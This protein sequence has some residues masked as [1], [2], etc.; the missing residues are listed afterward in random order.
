[1]GDRRVRG[2]RAEFVLLVVLLGWAL[3]PLVLLLIHAGQTH[4]SFTGA[5]GLIGADGVLGADQL[6]YLAWVRDSGSHGL[7]SDLFSLAPANHIYLQPLFLISGVLWRAGLSLQL[8]YLLWKPIAAVALFLAALAWGRRAFSD[9]P[10][11]RF[12]SVAL[13]L[14]LYTPLAA[15]YSWGQTGS[16]SFRFQL[17]LL[18][19]ELLPATKLWGYVPS[20]LALALVPVALLSTELAIEP[21]GPRL[22]GRW[23]VYRR[24]LVV[25]ALAAGFAAWL[26]PWQ[27]VTLIA[28]FAGLA[29][30]QRRPAS[31]YLAVPAIG[32]ALPLSY[33]FLLK[34]GDI[35][36]KLGSQY[37]VI[38]RLPPLVLL[39]GFGPLVLIAGF[40]LVRPR[41]SVFEQSVLLWIAGC[42]FTY[43]ANDAFAPHAL[44]G[45]SFPLAVLLVRGGQRL[46]LPVAVGAA[47]VALATIP[48]L[49]Y[50]ARK[51]VNVT[52]SQT[53]QYYLPKGDQQALDWVRAH[54]PG[55]G[56]LAPTPFAAVI[57]ALTGRQVWAGDGYWTP[58]Y[59]ERAKL[60]DRLFGGRIHPAAKARAFVLGTGASVLV[61][62]CKHPADV[63]KPL[64]PIVLSVHRF[65]C[66]RVYVV[67]VRRSASR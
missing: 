11:A 49:V 34:Q 47:L 26:H 20:A 28:V 35:A 8:A 37:E 7:I 13:A 23:G 10:A 62:D 27:G 4:T 9:Q 46:R 58:I 55:G 56:V 19:D 52:R 60:V 31:L 33:Y 51:F 5:D 57:P 42:F 14:F 15:L 53:V 32:A 65:D 59:P 41:G 25:A 48:G 16:G 30:W 36:W 54:A 12:A 18:G 64:A 38:S 39:A 66:A 17:F 61:S 21:E 50:D 1:M 45:L 63:G 22:A 2:R 40:G 29:V 67:L 3:F 24:G 6:Q 44:Q 43:F